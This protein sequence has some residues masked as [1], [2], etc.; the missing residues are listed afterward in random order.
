VAVTTLFVD[1]LPRMWHPGAVLRSVAVV[2]LPGVA[3]FELGVLCE[4]FGVDRTDQGVPAVDF[5]VVTAD[6]GPVPTSSVFSLEVPLGLQAAQDVDL[7]A[8]PAWAGSDGCGSGAGTGAD[9]RVLELL[10]DADARGAWVLSVCTGAFVVGEAGLLDGRRCTTHWRH[11]ERLARSYPRAR[12]D[13]DVLYVQ[14]GNLVTSAGTAAG[15]DAS[16][17]VVREEHGAAVASTIARRMVVPP[18]RDGG[19][20]QF[21]AAP[22][23]R[24]DDPGLAPVIQWALEHLHQDL[25]VSLLA[26]QA[27]MSERTFARRFR[28]T[29]GVS[30]AAWVGAQRLDRARTLLEETDLSVEEVARHAGF[31]SSPVLRAHFARIGTSPLAYRRTFTGGSRNSVALPT[32]GT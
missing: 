12:L 19:Q 21:V 16:L 8:V 20:A 13:P 9:P 7:V 2:A 1:F 23:P 28:A 18:H 24:C 14:D 25:P 11:T 26:R 15:I 29:T 4:V 5:R 10:R 27:R 22:V 32:T 3:P 30:P 17:H 6:P 31:G